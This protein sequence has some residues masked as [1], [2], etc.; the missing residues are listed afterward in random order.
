MAEM[1]ARL[2]ADITKGATAIPEDAEE[3]D[4]EQSDLS[5][6]SEINL[7]WGK[8]EAMQLLVKWVQSA[9]ELVDARP[10]LPD[11]LQSMLGAPLPGSSG[12]R[13]I[14]ES[15]DDWEALSSK[16][17]L[18]AWIRI[19]SNDDEI[20][21]IYGRSE[22]IFDEPYFALQSEA[23]VFVNDVLRR[24]SSFDED[25]VTREVET[26]WNELISGTETYELGQ[27]L[28]TVQLEGDVESIPLGPDVHLRRIEGEWSAERFTNPEK[29]PSDAWA[30]VARITRKRD[31]VLKWARPGG[32][33][34]SEK[35]EG[36][37]LERALL[38]LRLVRPT[39]FLL[40]GPRY[41]VGMHGYRKAP[42]KAF[43]NSPSWELFREVPHRFTAN[44]VTD[45]SDMGRYL[46]EP[47][48]ATWDTEDF[49]EID[50]LSLALRA[51][52]GSFRRSTWLD[53]VIDLAVALEALFARGEQ[54]ITHKAA[55]RA[56]LIA[57]RDAEEAKRIYATVRE[58]Y[59][60]R[61]AIV[62]AIPSSSRKKATGVI[63]EWRGADRIPQGVSGRGSIA[64][65]IGTEVVA[66]ALRAFLRL[67]AAGWE[68]FNEDFTSRMDLL[69][70]DENERLRVRIDAGVIR[71]PADTQGENASGAAEQ[72]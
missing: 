42:E 61:S 16:M 40:T 1:G 15:S 39:F 4:S 53:R 21:K 3:I 12:S 35:V 26:L 34:V 5:Y 43:S 17:L 63:R 48:I 36:D 14:L 25:A 27:A 46:S 55:T 9:F 67:Q 30:V 51:F 50:L 28:Y 47:R 22:R 10:P 32:Y 13:E 65:G 72:S 69:A 64:S 19:A 71:P 54:E 70:F 11:F 68:P 18:V 38:P 60:L 23:L 37:A 57:A 6:P 56:A 29:V 20:A 62:H 2:A 24:Y 49:A 33:G 66:L 52:N 58:F 41:R 7:S 59:G 45:I 44:E 8:A 31:A